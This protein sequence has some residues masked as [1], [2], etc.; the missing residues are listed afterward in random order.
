MKRQDRFLCNIKPW[1]SN[2]DLYKLLCHICKRRGPQLKSTSTF[3]L[4]TQVTPKFVGAQLG[5]VRECRLVTNDHTYAAATETAHGGPGRDM[6][7]CLGLG[8]HCVNLE[9][10]GQVAIHRQP[11]GLASQSHCQSRKETT[12]ADQKKYS[13]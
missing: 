11:P 13:F 2:C 4:K 6:A 10:K 3:S 12:A 7:P 5:T 9:D 1:S 8:A